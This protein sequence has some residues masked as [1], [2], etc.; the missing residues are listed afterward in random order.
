MKKNAFSVIELIF[1]IF[2][3]TLL[4]AVLIPLIESSNK[5]QHE[6]MLNWSQSLESNSIPFSVKDMVVI[7]G[8]NI[9]GVVIKIN[10]HDNVDIL[11]IDGKTIQNLRPSLLTK[12]P[13]TVE[14]P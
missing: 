12:V 6:I 3:I 10:I 2:I 7:S 14:N 8:V 11:T 13:V 1:V 5:R 4:A 9:T